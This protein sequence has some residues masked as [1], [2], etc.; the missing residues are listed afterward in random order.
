MLPPLLK[1]Q[2]RSQKSPVLNAPQTVKVPS[3]TTHSP[4]NSLSKE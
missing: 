3:D 1:S 2:A 4:S